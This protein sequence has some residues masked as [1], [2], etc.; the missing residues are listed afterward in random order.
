[1]DD[2][3]TEDEPTGTAALLSQLLPK[4][5]AI[6]WSMRP[7]AGGRWDL[8]SEGARIASNDPKVK[9][10]LCEPRIRQSDSKCSEVDSSGRVDQ[11]GT[12]TEWS[13]EWVPRTPSPK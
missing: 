8:S 13:P 11:K 7:G 10:V 2:G 6:K 4:V 3:L 12:P 5:D 9:N 1:M